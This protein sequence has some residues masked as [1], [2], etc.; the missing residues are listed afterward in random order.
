[1]SLIEEVSGFVLAG[2]RATRMGR[3]KRLFRMGDQTLLERAAALL[4]QLLG[5]PPF[6]VGD[7]LEG[8]WP[9]PRRII[10]DM[11]PGCGPLSG[12]A[13]LLQACPTRWALAVAADMPLLG[14]EDL[15][16]LVERVSDGDRV[17]ALSGGV[18]P[19]PLAAIYHRD[20]GDYWRR[21][22]E[23]GNYKLDSGFRELDWVKVVPAKPGLSL[24]NV[25]RVE[26]LEWLRELE[27]N[28]E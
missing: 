2:G 8:I 28:G 18:R 5:R 17:A 11:R 21:R 6:V 1:M 15:Q 19:E 16:L 24:F 9:D 3:D 10:T 14:A 22:L 20:T 7:N 13:A 27:A 23:A 12:L 25:N 26:D 4:E